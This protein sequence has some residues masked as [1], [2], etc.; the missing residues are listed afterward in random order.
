MLIRLLLG[1]L[2][3]AYNL[4]VQACLLSQVEGLRSGMT[5]GV[6]LQAAVSDKTQDKHLKDRANPFT[7]LS[8]KFWQ[9]TQNLCNL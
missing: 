5:D 8:L 7:N 6:P 3:K 9:E 4:L 2:V 1:S